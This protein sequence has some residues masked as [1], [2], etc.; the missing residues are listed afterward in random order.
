MPHAPWSS[1]PRLVGM[2]DR[3]TLTHLK[4]VLWPRAYRT[5]DVELLDQLLDDTFEMIH[6]D[7]TV[8]DKA[9]EMEAVATK[10]WDPGEFEYRIERLAIYDDM[11]IVSGQGVATAY[12]YRSSNVLVRRPEGWRA[13]SSHVSGVTER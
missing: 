4:T 2:D 11:A 9:H 3:A 5:Q 12:S 6:A 7:G 8:T 13:V 10:P 1:F